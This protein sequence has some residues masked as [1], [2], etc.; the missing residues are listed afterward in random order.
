MCSA[1]GAAGAEPVLFHAA[2]LKWTWL[3]H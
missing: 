2:C 1:I 3:F